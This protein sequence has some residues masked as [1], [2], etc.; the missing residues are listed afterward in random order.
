MDLFYFLSLCLKVRQV[1]YKPNTQMR[2]N[3]E[4]GAI[5]ILELFFNNSIHRNNDGKNKDF[6]SVSLFQQSK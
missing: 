1:A 2:R 5:A 6:S 3:Y 4:I